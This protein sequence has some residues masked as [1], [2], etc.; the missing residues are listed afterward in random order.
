MKSVAHGK[1][2]EGS[3]PSM[4]IQTSDDDGLVTKSDMLWRSE[5]DKCQQ[6]ADHPSQSIT[7][8]LFSQHDGRGSRH[9][10]AVVLH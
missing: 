7:W 9:E 4:L 8:Y 6:E 1:E 5:I 2:S 10:R 3:K